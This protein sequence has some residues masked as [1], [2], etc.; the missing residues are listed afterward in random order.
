MCMPTG[1]QRTRS[2]V[3]SLL[4]PC[5]C[6]DQVCIFRL[7]VAIRTQWIQFPPSTVWFLRIELVVRLG[8]KH[9]HLLS[10]FTIPIFNFSRFLYFYIIFNILNWK[11]IISLFPFL[12][13]FQ[14]TTP[15][16]ALSNSWPLFLCVCLFVPKYINTACSVYIILLICT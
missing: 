11:Y 12:L 15:H 13:T 3:C 8:G 1:G 4:W 6:W 10:H 16:F 9:L 2:G 14:C 5:G 7:A